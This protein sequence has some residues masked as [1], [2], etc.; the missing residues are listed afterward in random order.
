MYMNSQFS[1]ITIVRDAQIDFIPLLSKQLRQNFVYLPPD[2]NNHGVLHYIGTDGFSQP[3]KNPYLTGKVNVLAVKGHYL[4]YGSDVASVKR[5]LEVIVGKPSSNGLGSTS[6]SYPNCYFTIDL[7]PSVS[8]SMSHYQLF[9][10]YSGG[11]LLLHF[12]IKV[13]NDNINWTEVAKHDIQNTNNSYDLNYKTEINPTLFSCN[14]TEYFRY[15]KIEGQSQIVVSSIEL[16][17]YL[18]RRKPQFE[19]VH[20]ECDDVVY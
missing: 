14:S 13:S 12:T 5:Q 11:S 15:F 18:R 1:D 19:K 8:L 4:V 10:Y 2:V 9:S 20:N 3:W 7:G 16:Y 17:G 6:G